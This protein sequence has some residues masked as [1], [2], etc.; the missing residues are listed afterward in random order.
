MKVLCARVWQGGFP[1]VFRLPLTLICME[2]KRLIN[3][4]K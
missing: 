4:D 3:L 2:V 1:P